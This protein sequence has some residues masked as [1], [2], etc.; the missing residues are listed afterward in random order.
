[1]VSCA[2]RTVQVTSFIKFIEIA[3]PSKPRLAG[4]YYNPS[5][6]FDTVMYKGC[7]IAHKNEDFGDCK[8]CRSCA[9]HMDPYLSSLD[10]AFRCSRKSEA[11][12]TEVQRGALG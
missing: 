4:D 12:S 8:D 10:Q 3:Y 1:V 9:F 5:K 11:H 7:M 2:C 6:H